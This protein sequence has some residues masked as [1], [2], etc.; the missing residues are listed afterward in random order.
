MY[1]LGLINVMG[2][3]PQPKRQTG[4]S[5]I[6]SKNSVTP[7]SRLLSIAS[8]DDRN[9]LRHQAVQKVF[10]QVLIFSGKEKKV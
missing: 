9:N 7:F 5:E 3:D 4:A 8:E 6:A 2:S 10:I 1:A